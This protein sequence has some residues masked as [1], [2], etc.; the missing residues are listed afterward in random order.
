[1]IPQKIKVVPKTFSKVKVS[2]RKI[3]ESNKTKSIFDFPIGVLID[4]SK[5]EYALNPVYATVAHKTE[6]IIIKNHAK[7]CS[8]NLNSIKKIGKRKIEDVICHIN[9]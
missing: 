8:G 3:T 1:M 6:E 9:A 7:Y 2:F 5:R 4:T